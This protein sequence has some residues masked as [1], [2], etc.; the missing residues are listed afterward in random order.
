MIR[1]APSSLRGRAQRLA[2]ARLSAGTRAVVLVPVSVAAF[3]LTGIPAATAVPGTTAAPGTT[4]PPASTTPATS[5]APIGTHPLD[6]T[7]R[8]LPTSTHAVSAQ[9][10]LAGRPDETVLVATVAATSDVRTVASQV[11]AGPG[12]V[13]H[14]LTP[15]HRVSVSVPTGQIAAETARLE[16]LPGVTAVVPAAPRY[17]MAEPDDPSFADQASYYQAVSAPAAWSRTRGSAAVRIAVIDTGVDVGH[18]DLQGKVVATY[19]ATDGSTDVTD[20]VGHGTFVAGVAAAGTNNGI[21]VAGAGYNASILAVKVAASAAPYAIS[22][23]D[24]AAGIRWAVDHDARI[25]NISLGGPAADPTEQ[26]AVKYATDHGV[27]VVAAAGNQASSAKSYPAAWPGVI[28]V[29]ATDVSRGG[30]ASFSNYGSWVTLAAPGTGIYSTTPRSGS[31]LFAARYASGQGTSFSSP[32][33]AGAAA[34]LEAVNPS[35]T[36][37]EVRGALVASAHGYGGLGLG[38]GQVDFLG[39]LESQQPSTTPTGLGVDGDSGVVTVHA[40]STSAA[41]QFGFDGAPVGRRVP[42][43]N[44]RAQ[45][46]LSTFGYANGPHSLT[47]QDCTTTGRCATPRA[48]ADLTLDNQAPAVTGPTDGAT[49]SGGVTISATSS[50]GGVAFFVDGRRVGFDATAPFSLRLTGST[51][52]DGTHRVAVRQCSSSGARCAGPVGGPVTVTLRSLH[53]RIASLLSPFSP[54]ADGRRDVTS[55][56]F[57]LPDRESVTVTVRDTA[58]IAVRGP[59]ALG[60]LAP[61]YHSW[62]WYGRDNRGARLRDGRYTVVLSSAALVNGATLRGEL[63]RPVQLDT[64]APALAVPTA[65]RVFFPTVDGYGDVL[66]PATRLTERAW[67][68]LQVRNSRGTTV[69]VI[70]ALRDPGRTGVGWTGTAFS[71]VRLT[72]GWYSWRYAA[73]DGAGNQRATVY[74]LVYLSPKRLVTADTTL[75]KDA[76]TG[77]YFSSQ[78]GCG[79]VGR[80]DFSRGVRLVNDCDPARFGSAVVDGVFTFTLPAAVSYLRLGVTARGRSPHAPSEIAGLFSTAGGGPTVARTTTLTDGATRPYWAGTVA[81]AAHFSSARV[82]TFS[83]DVTNRHTTGTRVS[84]FDLATVSLRVTYRVLR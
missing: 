52:T 8:A 30:R 58:G 73:M 38:A 51:L 68:F 53:P 35:S 16:D 49:I 5:V 23:A 9:Q 42:V 64:V 28:A 41:V 7:A 80:S 67:L 1:H 32:L 25:I 10:A 72:P 70:R 17:V 69:R 21:G 40:T 75:S 29:G 54:N 62:R 60:T 22:T 82:V 15:L 46:T 37:A 76:T 18:P 65:P 34:L 71:G 47:A 45:L 27:L 13:Q 19:N 36:A 3:A 83:L 57:S 43:T 61:G 33:V 44:G 55:L 63:T 2:R 39:A 14:V 24:E 78:A 59:V 74:R 20:Q 81:A 50:G 12:T 11:D 48:T 66:T 26:A 4:P 79:T 6:P 84:D 31:Q 77:R 56:G